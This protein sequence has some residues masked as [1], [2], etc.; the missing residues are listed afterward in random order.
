[1][2]VGFTLDLS[3]Q[4]LTDRALIWEKNL[5]DLGTVLEEY[6]EVYAEFF[7]VN[8]GLLP[9]VMQE[10]ITDCGCT[11]AHFTKDTLHQDQ[12]GSVVISY[13]PINRGGKFSKMVVVKTNLDLGGDTIFVQGNNV[14]LPEDFYAHYAYK[15]G[16]MGFKFSSINMGEAFTG[17]KRTKHVDFYNFKDLPITIDE[18]KT[19]LPP[20][21]EVNMVPALVPAKSRGILEITYTAEGVDFLG[22]QD[23]IISFHLE[24]EKEEEVNLRLLTTVHEYFDPITASEAAN[25]PKLAISEVNLDLKEIKSGSTVHRSIT[26]SNMGSQPVNIR[27]V[28][29]NCECLTLELAKNDLMPGDK[30]EL[31]FSFDTHSRKGIDHKHIT[32]FSNDPLNPTRTIV[33]KS[34]IK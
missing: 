12:I 33:I 30:T 5:V 1:M 3:A 19:N 15:V 28:I 22:F 20:H 17:L 34:T 13:D 24:S 26:L 21:I 14:P 25:L 11:T 4:K 18:F 10:V 29:A 16:D 7:V 2:L 8:K 9:V 23:E 6:G 31:K 27:K 32:V